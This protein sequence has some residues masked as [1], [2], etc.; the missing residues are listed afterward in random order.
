MSAPARELVIVG[1]GPAGV[2]AALWARA[3]DLDT[4]VLEA[5]PVP[6]GQL[7]HV[8]FAPRELAGW[9]YGDGPALAEVYGRQL[10]EWGIPVRYEARVRALAAGER[11]TLELE[12][13]GRL[14]AKAVLVATGVRRR[15]LD[16]PGER[17]LEDRG[18]SYSANRDR[19]RLA[20]RAVVVVGGGDAA[21][22]N[23]AILAGLG[24]EVTLLV[25]ATARARREFRERARAEPRV[26]VLERTRVLRV[27]GDAGVRGVLVAGPEGEREL[28]CE[29]VMIKVGVE[30]AT[31]WCRDALAHDGDGYLR[32]DQH[33]ATS[34]AGV[35][36]AG[37]VTRPL[38]PS[39]PVAVG[40]G[41]LAVAEIRAALRD[42]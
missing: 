5:A 21:F 36:A 16:V 35:W 7:Q 39:V 31:E 38:L 4:L 22:E 11:I 15:R 6:G 18:V 27:L 13:G 33:F 24:C 14:G 9:P 37:D 8:H 17:E 41:A 10:A 23:A 3:R 20:G 19:E 40:Q 25:R 26:R 2:S 32:V 30:P 1:A 42:G 28:A 12:S 29:A 34:L